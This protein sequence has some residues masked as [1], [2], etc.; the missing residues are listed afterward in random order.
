[1]RANDIKANHIP[2]NGNC[3]KIR[4]ITNNIKYG[5]MT[6]AAKANNVTLSAISLAVRD[7]T[8]CNGAL[9]VLES[10][11]HKHSDKLCEQTAKANARAAKA[12]ERLALQESEMAE[13]RLWKAEREAEA[14]RQEEL[15]KA[16]EKR[17][18]KIAELKAKVNHQQEVVDNANARAATETNKLMALEMELEALMDEEV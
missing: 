16:K 1:M 13:F 17:E 2:C 18:R 10:E 3:K 7:G 11:L 14:K 9:F 6:E 4:D 12:N 5:S 15:C 8:P